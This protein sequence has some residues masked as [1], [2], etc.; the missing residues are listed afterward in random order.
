MQ[1]SQATP[2]VGRTGGKPLACFTLGAPDTAKLNRC[3][4]LDLTLHEDLGR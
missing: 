3:R 1:M 4:R 2:G